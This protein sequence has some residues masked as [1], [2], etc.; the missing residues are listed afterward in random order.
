MQLPGVIARNGTDINHGN[1]IAQKLLLPSLLFNRR[2]SA[3]DGTCGSRPHQ[4]M[5]PGFKDAPVEDEAEI[6]GQLAVCRDDFD[7]LEVLGKGGYGEVKLVRCRRDRQLYAMK[8]VEKA[9]LHERYRI[10]DAAARQRAQSERD[11][12]VKSQHWNCPFIIK[13]CAAFQTPEKLYYILEYCPGGDLFDLL[14][15]Q[16]E[17]CFEEADT[18]FYA[19]EV[20][21]ALE[22]L[23]THDTIHRDVKLENMLLSADGHVRLA[24][25]GIAKAGLSPEGN[26]ASCTFCAA[27]QMAVLYPPEFQRGELYG[28]DLDCWQLGVATYC[29]LT[30]TLPKVGACPRAKLGVHGCSSAASDFCAHLLQLERTTRLG[31]PEGAG[32]LKPHCFFNT[33]NWETAE[34]QELPLPNVACLHNNTGKELGSGVSGIRTTVRK[35]AGTLFWLQGFAFSGASFAWASRQ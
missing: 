29:M 32:Q 30:G 14:I 11:I 10:G 28:K 21:L 20:C 23:H 13:L 3:E 8:A 25:F 15:T 19:A 6:V 12:G 5:L 27:G 17:G 16:D 4:V 35:A 9:A 22:H 33:V 24:D 1:G 34:A 18:R 7:A 31:Y 2:C 26:R